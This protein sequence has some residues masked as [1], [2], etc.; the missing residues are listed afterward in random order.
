MK[1]MT[2][3]LLFMFLS[4]YVPAQELKSDIWL[5][6]EQLEDS[7]KVNPKPVLLYFHTDWCTYCRKMEAEV[8]TKPAVLEL[9]SQNFYAVKFNAEY[10]DEVIFD[11]R[12][13]SNQQL[14]TSRT[15]LHELA[16]LFNG[17][18]NTFA[19]PLLMLFDG[20]FIFKNRA[21]NYLD[22]KSLQSFLQ[23]ALDQN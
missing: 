5:D 17:G 22:S 19:P 16:I 11:G 12:I 10:P 8:F 13:F 4:G 23:S 9:L 15:P 7:L 18:E 6:F 20:Q 1:S 21:N 3:I 14:K 2:I